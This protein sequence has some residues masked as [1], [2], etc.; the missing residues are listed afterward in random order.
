MESCDLLIN[1]V[2]TDIL[3]WVES[4]WIWVSSY[5]DTF[6]VIV[7]LWLHAFST[8]VLCCIFIRI[9]YDKIDKDQNGEVSTEELTSWIR[10]VQMR[11]VLSDTD[12]QWRDHIPEDD[13]KTLLKWDVYVERTY[14]HVDGITTCYICWEYLIHIILYLCICS[15][16]LSPPSF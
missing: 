12:R 2:L 10:H 9:I 5:L 4:V 14:G 15:L 6:S 8:I 11:Y 1:A 13:D 7:W 3:V 16:E